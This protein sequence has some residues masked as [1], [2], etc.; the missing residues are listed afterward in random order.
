MTSWAKYSDKARDWSERQ[1]ADADA[2]LR[3]RAEL[4]R[5]LG[6]PLERGDSVLDLA[7]GDGAL[8]EFLPQQRYIGVD[9]NEQMVE[10]GR[11]RGRELLLADLNEYVPADKV[12]ATT[13]FRAIYYAND[14]RA[15]FTRIRG[16]TE[17]KVVFD[18]NPRQ[19]RLEEVRADLEAAGFPT[20][21]TRPFFVPQTR[22]VPLLTT[23]ERSGPLAQL[24]LRY[25]FT[26][27]CAA[28]A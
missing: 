13:I 14:R 25:R 22:S 8:A 15:L 28:S 1:Y 17:K 9:G 10:A 11:A 7:C 4:L 20:L 21:V 12:D 5:A 24:L 26:V 23:L 18:L 27:L 3:H 2:Y 19:Y 16:Y 6:P